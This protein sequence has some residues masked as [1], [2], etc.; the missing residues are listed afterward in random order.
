MVSGIEGCSTENGAGSHA[1]L[2]R[3]K[4]FAMRIRAR[5]KVY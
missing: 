5:N 2:P 1:C 4:T 3:R